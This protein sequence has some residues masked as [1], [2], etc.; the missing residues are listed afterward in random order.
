[1]PL[2]VFS[3]IGELRLVFAF[4]VVQSIGQGHFAV[5]MMVAISFTVGCD[6][7][8]LRPP[9]AVGKS[10]DEPFSEIFAALQ[11]ALEC[12]RL[13]DRTVVKENGNSLARTQLHL[14]GHRWIHAPAARLA[15]RTATNPARALGLVGRKNGKSNSETGEDV[16]DFHVDCGFGQPHAFGFAA[17]SKFEMTDSP[18]NLRVLVTTGR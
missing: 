7:N 9:P 15:P 16:E 18:Q 17:E 6:V 13:R 10:G 5:L 11:Q 3:V 12:D 14:V 2:Q 1:M 8:D 4:D